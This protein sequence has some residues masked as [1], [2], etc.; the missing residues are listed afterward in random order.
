MLGLAGLCQGLVERLA[1]R[2]VM[3]QHLGIIQS[4]LPT[5]CLSTFKEAE[6][7]PLVLYAGMHALIHL[8]GRFILDYVVNV[9]KLGWMHIES[10]CK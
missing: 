3:H 1:R 9:H 10:V 8:E 5:L 4:V 2:L 7:R 6:L